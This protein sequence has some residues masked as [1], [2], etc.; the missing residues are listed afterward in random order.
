[1]GHNLEQINPNSESLKVTMKKLLIV[2]LL[3]MASASAF[4]QGTV[5]FNNNGL[6]AGN[7][8]SIKVF[9]GPQSSGMPLTLAFGTYVAQLYY[10]APGAAES[11]LQPVSSPV[12]NFRAATTTNP[13]TWSGGTRTLTGF[14]EGAAVQLQVRVWN[15]A[16]GTDYTTAF[17]KNNGLF[18]GKSNPFA[19]TVP[20]AGSPPAAY[21][22]TGFQGFSVAVPEP[23]VIVLGI[24]GAGVF[25]LRRRK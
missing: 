17:G 15:T 2:G 9:Y 4:A 1:L 7:P 13:G 10:G 3:I 22:M 8:D 19:Y 5:N 25:L 11:T 12:S 21:L 24:L 18:T 14:A 16:D 20:A 6:L 23:S